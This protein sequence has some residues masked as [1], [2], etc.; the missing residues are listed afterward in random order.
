MKKLFK[1]ALLSISAC[2]VLSFSSCSSD[3]HDNN[4]SQPISYYYLGF[5]DVPS[6]LIANSTYGTNL[7][8]GA[9]D[10]ITTGYLVELHDNIYAQ[11]P[12]NYGQTYDASFNSVWGYS[13]Y[14]GGFAVSNWHDMTG[15][16]YENQMSVYNASSPSG[17]NFIVANGSSKSAP[18]DPMKAKYSD[19]DGCAHVYITNA[20]GY[21]VS[22]SGTPD[23][24][25]SGE[26]EEMAFVSVY[27]TNTTYAFLTMRDGD[28]Y[29]SALNP[30][31]KGWFKVQFIAFEDDDPN[32][33]PV[34]YTEIY[35]ANFDPS[36]AGGYMGIID[37][38]IEATLPTEKDT[39]ILVINFVGS[40]TGEYGLNTPAYCALD[41]FTFATFKD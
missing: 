25:V 4:D 35:L 27:V 23:S 33:G 22:N 17:G 8:Y 30:E 29:A 16:T 24:H 32:D 28:A 13:Y 9:Q 21:S 18:A 3:D 41:N 11:F 39:S 20:L 31:N 10:Q 26:S 12:V 37:E 14:N 7:Y 1:F 5:K 40:D 36:L 15:N 34:A 38:W 2:S 19:Y 6:D